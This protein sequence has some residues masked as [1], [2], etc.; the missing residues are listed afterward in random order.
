MA[1]ISAVYGKTFQQDAERDHTDHV[2]QLF[3]TNLANKEFSISVNTCDLWK[4][5]NINPKLIV[6]LI[7]E[8]Q[9]K[10]NAMRLTHVDKNTNWINIFPITAACSAEYFILTDL[11]EGKFYSVY[12]T[13]EK[14][15]VL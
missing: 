6:S 13:P 11:T 5:S 15:D 12:I 3:S 9:R 8:V 10:N 7:Q 1:S 14:M 4:N 2:L